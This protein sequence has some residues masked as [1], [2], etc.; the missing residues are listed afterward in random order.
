MT[1]VSQVWLCVLLLVQL[2]LLVYLEL[3]IKRLERWMNRLQRDVWAA[4]GVQ[5]KGVM[6]HRN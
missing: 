5:I 2:L 6:V 1:T 4:S 3:R